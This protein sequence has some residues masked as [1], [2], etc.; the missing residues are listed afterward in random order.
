M[1]F[2]FLGG[3]TGGCLGLSSIHN[4]MYRM[5]FVWRNTMLCWTRHLQGV[6]WFCVV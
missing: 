2:H 5:G 4:F 3:Y 6:E 1:C